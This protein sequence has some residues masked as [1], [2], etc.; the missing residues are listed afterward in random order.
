[1]GSGKQIWHL[2]CTAALQID[3]YDCV[4]SCPTWMNWHWWIYNKT[5][6]SL[7]LLCGH[8]TG[9]VSMKCDSL[10]SQQWFLWLCNVI[11]CVHCTLL[12]HVCCTWY[13]S[14]WM[15]GHWWNSQILS[16]LDLLLG[17]QTAHAVS[18]KCVSLYWI[19]IHWSYL[20]SMNFC[21]LWEYKNRTVVFCNSRKA[22]LSLL[23]VFAFPWL[24]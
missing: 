24:I 16:S 13:D 20:L 14:T 10:Y 7:D 5:L 2:T 4:M 12:W 6:L 8:Q 9:T 18:T 22:S 11:S 3:F 17:H 21:R 19:K 15:N 1:M 23:S